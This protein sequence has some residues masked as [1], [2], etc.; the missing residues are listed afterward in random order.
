[1]EHARGTAASVE[2][3]EQRTDAAL[4]AVKKLIATYFQEGGRGP[5][6]GPVEQ[7]IAR[8]AHKPTRERADFLISLVGEPEIA[9]ASGHPGVRRVAARTLMEMGFP[10]ALEMPPEAVELVRPSVPVGLRVRTWAAF[11]VSGL[12]W[13]SSV[14]I[15]LGGVMDGLGFMGPDLLNRSLA[16]GSALVIGVVHVAWGVGTLGLLTTRIGSVRPRR[17][18]RLLLGGVLAVVIGGIFEHVLIVPA[19]GGLVG[20]MVSISGEG[21]N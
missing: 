1:M 13:L 16:I 10:Y 2:V 19:L 21:T 18:R 7:A 17:A 4:L 20:W 8:L 15:S 6:D 12:F 3:G 14:L 11:A 5:L 9:T